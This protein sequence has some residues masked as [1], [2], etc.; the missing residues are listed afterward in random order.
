MLASTSK[1]SVPSS[2]CPDTSSPSS[3]QSL[4]IIFLAILEDQLFEAIE[5]DAEFDPFGEEHNGMLIMDRDALE[6]G[7]IVHALVNF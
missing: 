3:P 6:D 4:E 7:E 2:T 1:D 5:V